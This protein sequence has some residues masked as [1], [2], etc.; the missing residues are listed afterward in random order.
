MGRC[1]NSRA[2]H[3][4]CNR[5]FQERERAAVHSFHA[6]Q[7]ISHA[8][9][10][11]RLSYAK[12][13]LQSFETARLKAHFGP[14]PAEDEV[15]EKAAYPVPLGDSPPA[16]AGVAAAPPR[17]AA[18]SAAPRRSGCPVGQCRA[19]WNEQAGEGG[20]IVETHTCVCC[21]PEDTSAPNADSDKGGPSDP[22][23]SRTHLEGSYRVHIM[24]AKTPLRVS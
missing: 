19:C 1:G 22:P 13:R 3:E 16:A 7:R 9:A 24:G 10:R 5:G 12:R 6:L 14:V 21:A 11:A 20:G 15:E 17:A 23:P 8:E 2:E 18:A 4:K